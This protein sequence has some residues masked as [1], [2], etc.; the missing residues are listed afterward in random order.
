M[1]SALEHS[2]IVD[3]YLSLEKAQ[4]RIGILPSGSPAAKACHASPFG[5]IPKKSKPGKWRLIIDL[6]IPNGHSINDGIEKELCSLSYVSID[7][8]AL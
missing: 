3:D 7:A 2:E 1:S 5:V 4:G 6:F 8:D